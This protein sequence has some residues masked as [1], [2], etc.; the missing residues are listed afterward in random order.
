MIFGKSCVNHE[1][2][3]IPIDPSSNFIGSR[4][5]CGFLFPSDSWKNQRKVGG[6]IMLT[7]DVVLR[8]W[9]QWLRETSSSG[10]LLFSHCEP[11]DGVSRPEKSSTVWNGYALQDF[12]FSN[13]IV[14]LSKN[15]LAC[16]RYNSY[17][18]LFEINGNWPHPPM[19]I[20]YSSD[21][22]TLTDLYSPGLIFWNTP[23]KMS[24]LV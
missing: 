17:D 24:K 18:H 2:N 11:I 13:H 6:W 16:P 5:A 9:D 8:S 19:V 14:F 1:K 12:G 15:R 22:K 7:T 3:W 10:W 20:Y 23:M 4:Q 21:K